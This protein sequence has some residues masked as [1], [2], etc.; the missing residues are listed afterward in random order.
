MFCTT[1]YLFVFY[2]VCKSCI[3]KYLQ[4]SK[5]CPMC[6]IKIHETQPL[7]NLRPDRTMQDVVYRLVPNLFEGN[8]HHLILIK[9]SSHFLQMWY[10]FGY[11]SPVFIVNISQELSTG[12][13]LQI[14]W[15]KIVP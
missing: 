9:P 6:N 5:Q 12:K 4:M 10:E 14:I 7:I 15:C 2:L 8:S 1:I 13:L 11:H 3:V